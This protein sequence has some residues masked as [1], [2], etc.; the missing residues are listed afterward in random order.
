MRILLKSTRYFSR[1]KDAAGDLK[2]GPIP[3]GTPV[4]LLGNLNLDPDDRYTLDGKDRLKQIAELGIA[5]KHDLM[6]AGHLPSDQLPANFANLTDMLLS[7]SKCPDLIVNRGHYFGTDMLDKSENEP[8]L[9][10]D[11]K[12]ALIEFLKTF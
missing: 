11:D 10:A 6:K 2:I 9:S 12:R 7:V 4:G 5:S 8:G 3:K 1:A